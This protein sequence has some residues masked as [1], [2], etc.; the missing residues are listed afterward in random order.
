[1]SGPVA[2]RG[3]LFDGSGY[4]DEGRALV[5]GLVAAGV[6][7][8]LADPPPWGSH[9]ARLPGPERA[10][11]EGLPP[12]RGD[13]GVSVQ[14]C[15]PP[16][17]DVFTPS[18]ARVL[19]T[20]FETDR[21]GR[22]WVKRC[23]AVDEVWVPTR[24]NVEGFAAS[25]VDRGRL[26]VVPS[27]IEIGRYDPAT[28]PFPIPEAHG[29]VFL[30]VFDWSSRKGWDVLLAAWA[31]AFGPADDVCLVL[32]VWPGR[33][34]GAAEYVE[35]IT[36]WAAAHGRTPD[37][38]ADVVLLDEPLSPA[39][40]V[41]LYAAC[42]VVVSAT[43]GEG[44][45]RPLVEA[46]A[47]GRPVVATDWSGPTE[48][49]DAGC[50]WPIPARVVDVPEVVWT[51]LP[52]FRGHRWAEPDPRA[53]AAALRDAADDPAGRER[54]GRAARERAGRFAADRVA[55]MAAGRLAALGRTPTRARPGDVRPGLLLEADPFGG[56][57]A[58]VVA[59]ALAVAVERDG[60][61][62][63]D[64]RLVRD[65]AQDDA[66]ADAV[67][68]LLAAPLARWL[69][70]PPA[71]HLRLRHPVTADDLAPA[72]PWSQ[73]IVLPDGVAAAWDP[74]LVAPLGH[75]FAGVWTTGP[76]GRDA[77]VARG[78][79]PSQA[80]LLPLPTG[81]PLAGGDLPDALPARPRM[82]AI[83]PSG[84]A[85]G[86]DLLLEA[87]RIA[88]ADAPAASLVVVDPATAGRPA[89]PVAIRP[90]GP[91]AG[92]W[93]LDGAHA[94]Q[95]DALIGV[96]DVLVHT[97]RVDDLGLAVARACA[98]RVPAVVPDRGVWWRLGLPP[99]R[100]V[101]VPSRG[102]IQPTAALPAATRSEVGWMTP[103]VEVVEADLGGL[104]AALRHAAAAPLRTPARPEPWAMDV[105]PLVAQV[106]AGAGT[107]RRAA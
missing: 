4:A 18:G 63:L 36:R 50:G 14:H 78:L 19:R 56:T 104:A 7:L 54:R 101:A 89:R 13:E 74:G 77:L 5:R 70:G 87:W 60:R 27:P 94:G 85:G 98:L 26:V 96:S 46:M 17:A 42:D 49:L 95:I 33:G 44:W 86:L 57:D 59:R 52:G 72:G 67:L 6:D 71:L 97:P 92:A 83:V 38:L 55:T 88:F 65:P 16:L 22:D 45:G 21:I 32:K 3:P 90:A 93:V 30:S 28:P 34:R 25:G 105:G 91:V 100:L 103:G 73:G 41:A 29:T 84:W 82:L 61:L 39:Q 75:R 48:Y 10:F 102:W 58:A 15:F 69:A 43:R 1:M 47:M 62:A 23:N 35:G 2:W 66:D 24:H 20:M 11:L 64:L 106:L 53:L 12:A 79:P 80:H 37:E 9:P 8:R 81:D 31:D 99:G 107:G 51:E 68:D 40:M 76:T